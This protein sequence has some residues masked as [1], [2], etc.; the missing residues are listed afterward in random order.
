M[1]C[2]RWA[3]VRLQAEQAA[4][5]APARRQR[6]AEW[7][8]WKA[9]VRRQRRAEQAVWKAHVR[10]QRRAEWAAWK[11]H[12]QARGR[13]PAR[14]PWAALLR[15]R[16]LH[17]RQVHG[18]GRV[19][20]AAWNLAPS[21]QLPGIVLPTRETFSPSDFQHR[22]P[23][24]PL[25]TGQ[26]SERD[27]FEGKMGLFFFWVGEVSVPHMQSHTLQLGHE[28]HWTFRSSC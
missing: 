15:H 13:G 18:P 16:P 27:R 9:H 19:V 10:R 7:A 14:E 5:K 12:R 24:L 26:E 11:C 17:G 4:W 3:R 2:D 28:W 20:W 22:P 6:R 23:W 8:A 21:C 1:V 25:Y